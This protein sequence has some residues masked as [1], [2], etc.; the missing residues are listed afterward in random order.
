M[1]VRIGG[2]EFLIVMRRI[3]CMDKAE[4]REFLEKLDPEYMRRELAR[5]N[6]AFLVYEGNYVAI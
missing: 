6:T 4:Q 5:K 3:R 1:P 2:N